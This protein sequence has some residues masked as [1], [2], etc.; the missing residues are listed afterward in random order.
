M[1]IAATGVYDLLHVG[2][3]GYFEKIKSEGD[4]LIV[5]VNDDASAASYKRVPVIPLDQR[6]EMVKAL[7]IVDEV[8]EYS[9]DSL[10]EE[11]L[12]KYRI[13]RVYQASN[14]DMWQEYYRPAIKRGVMRFVDYD[15]SKQTT[16]QIIKKIQTEYVAQNSIDRYAKSTILENERV[17]GDGFQSLGGVEI[18]ENHLPLDLHPRKTLEIGC[19]LGGNS[20]HLLN[21]YEGISIDAIDISENM[22]DLMKSRHHNSGINFVETDYAGW[23]DGERYDF[24]LSRDVLLYIEDKRETLNKVYRNMES[25]ATFL[26]YDYCDGTSESSVFESYKE[27]RGWTMI[28]VEEYEKLLTE[29]GFS[30]VK[31]TD[32]SGIYIDKAGDIIKDAT[33]DPIA[34]T[35]MRKKVSYIRNRWMAW[36]V[37]CVIKP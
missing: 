7:G 17:Y 10:T 15:D 5:L 3:I 27:S 22:I 31:S 29:V 6:M 9:D 20:L 2:H 24:V 11:T 14:P 8:Y 16:S 33:L 1:R 28:S 18:L 35:N 19:G 36:N 34:I 4:I 12:N 26:L 13:D 37:F 30:I 32:L 25:G 21:K 23:P